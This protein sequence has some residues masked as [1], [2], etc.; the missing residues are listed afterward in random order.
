MPRRCKLDCPGI[1][2]R[3]RSKPSF[4]GFEVGL[5]ETGTVVDI[6]DEEFGEFYQLTDQ[7][8][9][10]FKGDDGIEWHP[11]TEPVTPISKPTTVETVFKTPVE[12]QSPLSP[13]SEA[14][15]PSKE[16]S[17]TEIST[18]TT[19]ESQSI[20]EKVGGVE[21]A[22][23][24]PAAAQSPNPAPAAASTASTAT[25][26]PPVAPSTEDEK[27]LIEAVKQM[28][29]S[30]SRSSLVNVKFDK[31]AI[32]SDIDFEDESQRPEGAFRSSLAFL[33]VLFPS[34]YCTNFD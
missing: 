32:L 1:A 2:L 27:T 5:L 12:T 22:E 8:G 23:A 25:V 28:E 31:S 18:S 34:L 29:A 13:H 30:D 33:F 11:T 6:N 14:Q 3:I 15:S 7:R 10:V 20:P 24:A 21:P 9:Y 19:V 26:A 4:D 17:T 16:S